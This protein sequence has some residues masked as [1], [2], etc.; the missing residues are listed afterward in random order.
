[1]RA[2]VQHEYGSPDVLSLEDVAKPS[3]TKNDDVLIHVHA[4]AIHPG[5]AIQMRGVPYVVRLIT[6]LRR[7]KTEV[8][9]TDVA[10]RV[11]AV[12]KNVKRLRPGDEVFG[13]C[14]GACAEY[15][16]APESHFVK[17]PANITFAQAAT[18]PMSAFTAL[19]ALRDVGRVQPGQKVLI[20]GAAGG[21]GT[22]AVQIAKSFGAEV[23][24]VCSGR[25]VDMVRSL[26]AD[27]V[28]DYT[29]EDFTKAQR[30][31]DL[32]LDNVSNHSLSELR[33]VLTRRGTL[34]PNNGERGGGRWLG[35]GGSTL[36][37][38]LLSLFVR[39]K[40][41]PFVSLAKTGDLV[42]LKELIESGKVTPVI[43]RSYP[44]SETAAA[45]RHVDTGHARGKVVITVVGEER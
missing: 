13:W 39:Q 35:A 20:N 18:V 19:Q 23:T 32:I 14:K 16:C 10:G 2:I 36:K 9:A 29:Q 28:I 21:I 12:G 44:L 22:F 11:E 38:L 15:A 26:G 43:D 33:G 45:I 30:H 42:A 40:L 37:E 34:I 1:M 6:G 31:Y 8:P 17:K 7:P 25:N 5:D 24:G 41:R 27:H 3:I 4:A